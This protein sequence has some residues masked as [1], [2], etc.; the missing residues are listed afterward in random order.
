MI[1]R[2]YQVTDRSYLVQFTRQNKSTTNI[3]KCFLLLLYCFFV[4]VVFFFFFS[5][6]PNSI[7]EMLVI[8]IVHLLM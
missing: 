7:N 4:V 2:S 6:T 1:D 5:N 8:K 3:N